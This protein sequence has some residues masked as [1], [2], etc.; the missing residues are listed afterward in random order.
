VF[1]RFHYYV[2]ERERLTL[3][4]LHKDINVILFPSTV[5]IGIGSEHILALC[6]II[7]NLILLFFILL[8]KEKE[9]LNV[10]NFKG[11]NLM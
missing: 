6:N 2:C 9:M 11:E 1:W 4:E 8:K 3:R 7:V 5:H 10:A